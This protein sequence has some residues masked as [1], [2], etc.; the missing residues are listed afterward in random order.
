M[1][2]GAA[3]MLATCG[4]APQASENQQ[5][6][7]AQDAD[8]NRMVTAGVML[9]DLRKYLDSSDPAPRT[10]T[11][12]RLVFD[13]S[14]S[15]V[16]AVDEQTL[17][18]LAHT[19]ETHGKVRVRIV[20]YDDGTGTPRNRTSLGLERANAVAVYLQGTGLPTGTVQAEAGREAGGTRP[21]Q[22]IVLQK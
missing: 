5:T 12:D 13:R 11:F 18:A 19:L 6:N 17:L 15:K 9:P 2:V 1:A 14:S 10:F 20:G 22:L 16:R 3:A 4:Q 21:R 8:F 7:A